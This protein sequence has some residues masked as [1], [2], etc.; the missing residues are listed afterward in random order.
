[1]E[2]FELYLC[3]LEHKAGQLRRAA[4]LL[5]ILLALAVG[6]A[7]LFDVAWSF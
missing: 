6:L 7:I 1:M 3:D 4:V 2:D 5:G